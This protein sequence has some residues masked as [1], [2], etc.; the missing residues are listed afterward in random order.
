MVESI[1]HLRPEFLEHL[2]YVSKLK[3]LLIHFSK[4]S[5][6]REMEFYFLKICLLNTLNQ[7]KKTTAI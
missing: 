2:R 3:K 4:L 1:S 6:L 7:T 5:I